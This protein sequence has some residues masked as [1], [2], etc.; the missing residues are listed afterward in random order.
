MDGAW[1]LISALAGVV[2]I[3]AD[4]DIVVSGIGRKGVGL[5]VGSGMGSSSSAL[6]GSGVGF[7]SCSTSASESGSSDVYSSLESVSDSVWGWGVLDTSTTSGSRG[8]WCLW[9]SGRGFRKNRDWGTF[10]VSLSLPFLQ[11]YWSL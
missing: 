10:V 11:K 9:C 8:S 6:L 5:G 2:S 4:P 7:N 3:A 1:S